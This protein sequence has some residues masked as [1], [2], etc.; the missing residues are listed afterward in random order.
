MVRG[1]I[2]LL[3]GTFDPVHEG[4]LAAA[5]AARD[6]LGLDRVVVMPS[7]HP[8]HRAVEPRASSHHRFA[9]I[10]LAI[11]GAGRLEL[12]DTE[13]L[14]GGPS[15]TATTLRR[16]HAAG[17]SAC[18]ICFIAGADAFA[19]IATWHDYP[20][21][22]DL[23]HFAVVSRPGSRA[24]ALPGRLPALA[25]RMRP[26]GEADVDAERPWILLIEADTPDVSSTTVRRRVRAGA[27]LN[28]LVPPEVERYIMRQGL[29]KDDGAFRW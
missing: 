2:G 26:A 12:S 15:Y 19:E 18:E 16:L 28:G 20:A 11:A 3:G 24:S 13:L 7:H 23:C 6:A 25:A 21:L 29:Y 5:R 1:R 14:A 22:L 4:H 8:P 9:M 10:A 17:L 27:S